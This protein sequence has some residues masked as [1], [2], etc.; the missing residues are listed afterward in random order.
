MSEIY[1][2]DK[3]YSKGDIV[4]LGLD[5]IGQEIQ[6]HFYMS[7]KYNNNEPISNTAYWKYLGDIEEAKK[8]DEVEFGS[9]P[10]PNRISNNNSN[11]Q[12]ES[13][14]SSQ[15]SSTKILNEA[16][17]GPGD[18]LTFDNT[19]LDL[20]YITRPG[21]HPPR[22]YIVKLQQQ[23]SS[24]YKDLTQDIND[25]FINFSGNKNEH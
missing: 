6:G 23:L 9:Y 12:E 18:Y 10:S 24:G 20:D 11:T 13:I 15:I 3:I 5:Y 2:S 19:T 21:E 17:L 16:T 1:Q 14:S 7:L 25:A 4:R 8:Y 22:F